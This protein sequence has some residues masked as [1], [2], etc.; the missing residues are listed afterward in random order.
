MACHPTGCSGILERIGVTMMAEDVDKQLAVRLKPG[1][2]SLH[3]L[4]VIFHMFKHLN[5]HH[6]IKAALGRKVIDVAGPDLQIQESSQIRLMHDVLTLRIRI[7]NRQNRCL[8]ITLGYPQAE[9]SPTAA[10][11]KNRLTVLQLSMF[12]REPQS[13]RFGLIECLRI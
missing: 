11:F 1:A 6:S 3:Q 8:W 2:D 10:Q 12:T 5:R 7:R 9:R 13:F 4:R